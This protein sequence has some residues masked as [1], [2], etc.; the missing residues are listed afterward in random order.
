MGT[1]PRG[2]Y[3]VKAV[4]ACPPPPKASGEQFETPFKTHMPRE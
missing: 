3:A 1:G 4:E 2:K